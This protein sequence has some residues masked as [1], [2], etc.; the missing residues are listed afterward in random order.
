M[1]MR[2]NPTEAGSQFIT[3][4]N[5]RLKMGWTPEIFRTSTPQKVRSELFAASEKFFNERRLETEIADALKCEK[6]EQ[7]DAHFQERFG[8]GLPESMRFL[9][10]SERT[11]AIKARVENILRSE[12]L[13]FER[14]ILLETLDGSWKDHLYAMDQLRDS[15]SFRAFSQNDPRIEYKKEGSH[16]FAGMLKTVRERVTE[17]VFKAKIN[18]V[19]A[20]RP[21]APRPP[22]GGG[23]GGGGGMMTSGIIGPGLA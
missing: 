7:L 11:D 19:P 3:W 15:I 18:P 14:S 8:M 12:L 21:A 16:M 13:Y 6:D 5:S 2:Q 10:G 17:Y 23:G 9:E 1:L 4:A 22:M 20:P